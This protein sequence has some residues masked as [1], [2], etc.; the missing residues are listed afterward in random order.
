MQAIQDDRPD[1]AL[2]PWLL[3]AIGLVAGLAIHFI[4]GE[5]AASRPSAS[6]I[7]LAAFTGALA[8]LV[9][10]TLERT[11]WQWSL[12]FALAAALVVALI[13]WWNGA[14]DDWGSAEGWRMVCGFLAVA[15]A[16]PLFQA[17]RDAGAARFDYEE[18][19]GHAWTNVVMWCAACAF[20]GTVFLL[21][22]VL[23]ELFSLI[24][25][26]LLSDAL[27]EQWFG[28][29]LAGTAFGAAVGVLRERDRIVRLL[30]N[31]VLAVLGVLAPVLA[32]GL[33]LFLLSLPFTG[34]DALWEATK[35]TTPI[36]LSCV[37]GALIL[38]NAVVGRN[39]E[40]ESRFPPLRW[41]AMALGLTMLPLAV[42]A[43]ISTGTR[44]A[45]YGF[46]PDRLWA[47]VFV[48]VAT[49]YGLAYLVALVRGR[50]DWA[51]E[52]RPANLRL[53]FGLCGLALF[54]AL[55]IL[56]FNAIST[57]DQV[58]RLQDGR[59]SP[60]KFD[61]AALRFDFGE[62]GEAAVK[63]LAASSS[64]ELRR[65]AEKAVAAENRWNVDEATRAV[66]ARQTLDRRLRVLPTA[67]PVPP[68]LMDVLANES[69]CASPQP[70]TLFYQA[71]AAEA[72]VI[73][74]PCPPQPA[75]DAP[76]KADLAYIDC[77]VGAV[78]LVAGEKGW[79]RAAT[80][81]VE[82][83]ADGYARDYA[84]GRFEVRTVE[85]RQLFLN[86]KPIDEPF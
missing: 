27:K 80:D 69:A 36:L 26:S 83:D 58:A 14:P 82:R 86:D 72:F 10:F 66:E 45:Q 8:L 67:V 55:P 56:S 21:G 65:L 53:A 22:Y 20:V 24:G 23:S 7:A 17:A 68:A 59:V 12:I 35:S 74:A 75:E 1:W 81:H 25:I 52:L 19:H 16:A 5:G 61:W 79:A 71:G 49:A 51:V 70:C 29:A 31:V 34:L 48:I 60:G 57:R 28:M 2:R 54:L 9:G 39:A 38:A 85:R 64:P 37:I 62:P 33:V 78:R 30:L 44:I 41:G 76:H 50:S 13:F 40:E 73:K 11:R 32:I 4:I 42:I 77:G 6:D 47:L 3:A 84:G 46:T 15:I 43:A 63:R 18:V